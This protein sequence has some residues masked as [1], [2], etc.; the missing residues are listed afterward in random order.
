M[1]DDKFE[2]SKEI[3]EKGFR[4]WERFELD[5][6]LQV[7]EEGVKRF[8]EDRKLKLGLAFT[9]L[10]LGDLPQARSLFEELLALNT[11]DD[12]C[13]WGLGRIHLLLSN[14]GE[15]RYAFDQALHLGKPDERV[16]LDVA[17]E[18]YLLSMYE[19]A[20]DF[21]KRAYELNK[22][23]ADALLGLGATGYWLDDEECEANLRKALD[24]DGSYHD[25]RNFLANMYYAQ[26]RFEEAL[27]CFEKIPI[28][29]QN[30]PVSV[31]RLIRLLRRKGISE[32]RLAPLKAAL[33]RLNKE[34]GWDFFLSQ[35]KKKGPSSGRG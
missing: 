15:A 33:K 32:T 27:E 4:L 11:K 23:S 22:K 14:Y 28:E 9:R 1:A 17:R 19:E 7:F 16:L 25:A 5:E 8:P 35:I 31:R 30:D 10:D 21:Y 26:R 6:A 13:W 18:W 34:Q 3:E 24:I 20:H 2:S 12:E 29:A